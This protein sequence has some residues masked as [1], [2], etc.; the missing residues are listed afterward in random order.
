MELPKDFFT[1]ASML[2]LSG[3]TGATFVVCNGLQRAFDFNPKWLGLIVAILIVET[4]V[5][6][7]GAGAGP[8]DYCVGLINGFLVFCS[9]AGAT[10]AA[11]G[12]HAPDPGTPKGPADAVAPPSKGRRGFFTPWL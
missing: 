12:G 10:G 8:I 3:A 2:T 1:V 7:S 5:A 6:V 9:A 11:N 4:G